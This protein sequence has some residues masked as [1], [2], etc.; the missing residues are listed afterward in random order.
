MT[1]EIH[2]PELE[3][4]IQEHMA[5]GAFASVE[6]ALLEALHIDSPPETNAA[7]EAKPVV[8]GRALIEAIQRLPYREIDLDV[9]RYPQPVRDVEL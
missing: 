5:S 7:E 6:D 1:I 9:P 4:L 8:T 3:K 2:R